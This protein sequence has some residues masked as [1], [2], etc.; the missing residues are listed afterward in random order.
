MTPKNKPKYLNEAEAKFEVK[1][2]IL[3]ARVRQYIEIEARLVSNIKN[4]M[5]SYGGSVL[6]DYSQF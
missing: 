6:Q 1:I 3:V 4:I 2:Y 5:A